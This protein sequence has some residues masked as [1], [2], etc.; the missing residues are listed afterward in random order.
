L[1]ELLTEP[2]HINAFVLV[3][4]IVVAGFSVIPY[5]SPFLVANVGLTES[6]L[7][8]IYLLG[9]GATI[10]T[11]VLRQTLGP[12]GESKSLRMY[13]WLLYRSNHRHY[14]PAAASPLD[15]THCHDRVHDTHFGRWVPAM[16]MVTSSVTPENGGAS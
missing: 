2:S 16:A 15:R 6:D 5:L 9:G 3:S 7:P 10:F 14:E 11:S 4:A 8:Y 13:H 12:V 1:L